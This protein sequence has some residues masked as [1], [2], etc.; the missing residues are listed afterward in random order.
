MFSKD[1]DEPAGNTDGRWTLNPK[2]W[3]SIDWTITIF[4][5]SAIGLITVIILA[6]KEKRKEEYL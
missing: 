1:N 5:I 6:Y 3:D 4:F 2:T